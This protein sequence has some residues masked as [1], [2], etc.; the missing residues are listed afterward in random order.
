MAGDLLVHEPV[1][2]FVPYLTGKPNN[3]LCCTYRMSEQVTVL[4]K[5]C[6]RLDSLEMQGF[7]DNYTLL[8]L[9]NA[10]QDRYSGA[11]KF[12]PMSRGNTVNRPP[13]SVNSVNGPPESDARELGPHVS[14]HH[15]YSMLLSLSQSIWSL[16]KSTARNM[17][18]LVGNAV[19][20]L[21]AKQLRACLSL[22]PP[23]HTHVGNTGQHA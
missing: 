19:C 5:F 18:R 1:L 13:N 21:V 6:R 23:V 2:G 17:W 9:P 12:S 11:L 22:M 20:V 16:Q 15:A 7:P 4:T 10:V 3:A 8:A 14:L